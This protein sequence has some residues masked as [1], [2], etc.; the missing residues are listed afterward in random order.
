MG[1]II[2][3]LQDLYKDTFGTKPA[4]VK[5][6]LPDKTDPSEL[7][8]ATMNEKPLTDGHSSELRTSF[9]GVEI[10]LPTRFW[11]VPS[12]ISKEGNLFLPYTVVKISSKKTIV[13]TPLAERRGTVKEQ[14]NIED[15][16]ISLNGFVIDEKRVWPYSELMALKTLY[17]LNYAVRM[18]NAL[19]DI[20]IGK[21][22]RVV[23]ESID[24]P[25][26]KGGRNHVRPFSMQLESDTV[27]T[28]ESK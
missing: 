23:I 17:E 1:S 14:Y 3:E 24:F 25:E 28:L 20:F 16:S 4:I 26:V 11:G 12:E 2:F 27:F 22:D 15:Y 10:W 8:L 21:D 13:K 9:A 7:W 19:T 5:E 18:S 6:W